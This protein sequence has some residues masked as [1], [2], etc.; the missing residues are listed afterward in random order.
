MRFFNNMRLSQKIILPVALVLVVSLSL[1]AWLI[2]Y[3]GSQAIRAVA[4]D[5]LQAMAGEYANM[6]ETTIGS[7]LS[8]GGAVAHIL[9]NAVRDSM[10]L[11]R[12]QVIGMVKAVAENNDLLIGCGVIW[13]PNA[14]DGRDADYAGKAPY[15]ANGR[16]SVYTTSAADGSYAAESVD[17]S[18]EYYVEPKRRKTSYV[19]APYDFTVNGKTVLMVTGCV[20]IMRGNAFLGVTTTDVTLDSFGKVIAGLKVYDSGFAVV[21]TQ[22]GTVVAHKDPSYLNKDM[23]ELAKFD[24]PQDLKA[25]MAAGRPYSETRVIQGKPM[26]CYYEPITF[27]GT[28]QVWY[29]LIN[30]PLDEVLAPATELSHMAIYMSLGVLV[31]VLLVIVL[32]ARMT[33][34]PIIALAGAAENIA[35]GR[36]D[37]P[38]DTD[39]LG[40]EVGRLSQALKTMIDS[41]L[42]SLGEAET[43][44]AD[45]ER[46]AAKATQAMKEA[47]AAGQEASSKSAAMLRAADR[48]EEVAGIVSSA[49]TQLSAQIEQSGRGAEQQAAMAAETA[50]AMEEMT[51]TVVEVAKNAGSASDV[52]AQTRR[53]AEEG[54][55]VVGKA[56]QS[57]QQ[58][59]RESLALKDAM[60]ELSHQAQS[61]SQIMGVISDIADQ[62]NL[63]ALNAAIEAARAGEAGR[64]FA[65]VADE[66]RKL[67]EKTMTSTTD[68]GNAIRAIQ[69]SAGKSMAQVDN[70]VGMI[71]ETTGYA[72]ESGRALQEIVT[73]ADQTAE[74]V[75][76]IATASEEQSSASEEIS[77]S[78]NH[79]NTIAGETARAMAEA[80]QAVSDLAQQANSLSEL[81]EAMK[82]V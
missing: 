64:G 82:R 9:S 57:I 58:V 66:V 52:S 41:L 29:L 25:A 74:Q 75:Q 73:M 10:G 36:L 67:A 4:E 53:K 54:A 26:L 70:A 45:A 46:Q 69:D 37:T 15:P 3:R 16:F 59:Q 18:G 50:T 30:A 71:E 49:S 2:Q 23:F 81:I 56:V 51:A 19:T 21:L 60:A 5:Q 31:L 47:E 12:E 24:N 42:K 22:E 62:T 40:G 76:G 11:S 63:L 80:S 77:N 38:I 39:G 28:D 79:V 35:A 44:K 72:E 14:F 55:A 48:L 68:V 17:P 32:V 34:R 8:E 27:Q 33:A 13:E 65:V 61:I 7:T 43:M 78:V 20:P 6:I 1:L